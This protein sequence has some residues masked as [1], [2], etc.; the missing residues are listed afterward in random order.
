MKCGLLGEKLS[1][2]F[3]PQIHS[4][5]DNYEYRLYEVPP[6][7]LGEFLKNGDFDALNV[8]VP[9]KKAVIPYLSS[10][11]DRAAAIGSVNVIT[12]DADGG[13][14]GDN[15]DYGGFMSLV[16]K[17]GIR[18][19]GEKVLVLGSGGASETVRAVLS[20]MGAGEIVVISRSGENN[21]GNISRHADCGVI[22]N[23]TPVG[24]YPDNGKSPLPLDG[25]PD[26]CG[27]I[28]IIFNPLKTALVLDAE[29]RGIRAV[30]GLHM[31]VSQAIGS[32]EMFTGKK[33]AHGLCG[34]IERR[35]SGQNKNVVLIGMPGCGKTVIGRRLAASLGREFIDIDR[36]IE[37][38]AGK[39]IPQIFEED[40]EEEFRRIETE[41]CRAAGKKCGCIISCGGGVVT[42]GENRDPLRQNGT[43]VYLIRSLDALATKNRPLYRTHTAAELSAERE[44]LYRAWADVK[45]LNTGIGPTVASLISFLHL[46]K[47]DSREG[48]AEK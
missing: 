26:L 1:H 40:G 25:F 12:R 37:L 6:E 36:E 34:E 46:K 41:C 22:V 10:M 24:M 13:L 18:V 16:K 48:K 28:D 2:S 5:I 4:M 33:Y 27:V 45:M 7:E 32:A 30:G 39:T 21:Y 20:H 47:S 23:T 29:D 9:Y 14:V 19:K 8:T 15:A 31:L 38:A 3:S 35:I 44:P 42:R 17:S 43:I 11:T